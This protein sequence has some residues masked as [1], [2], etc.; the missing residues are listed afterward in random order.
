MTRAYVYGILPSLASSFKIATMGEVIGTI[1]QDRATAIAGTLGG[2]LAVAPMRA[3]LTSA[4]EDLAATTRTF[5]FQVPTDQTFTPLL[6]YVTLYN[7]LAAYER[8]FGAATYAVRSRA[9]IKGHGDLLLDDVFAG[10]NSA[11][12]AA[13]AIAGPLTLLLGNDREPITLDGLD[14]SL[15]STEASRSARIERVWLDDARPRAGRTVPLKVLTRSFRGEEKISTVPIEIP[16]NVSGPLSILVTDGKQL[17]ASEARELR[18][19]VQPQSVAQIIRVLNDTRRNNRIYVRLLAGAP[20]AVVNGEA[21]TSLP[22]SVLAVLEGD[23]NGGSFS[24]IRSAPV[25]QWE[26]PMDSA[27]IGSR[28]LAIDVEGRSPAGR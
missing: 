26:L 13:T 10:E 3:P 11:L 27:V 15:E 18:R 19:T 28:L 20:G 24:P 22:P 21:L 9:H 5:T 2:A 16:A 4:R 7:T 17:N 8:Q 25:G 23:S 6:S 12:G 14:I 1:R